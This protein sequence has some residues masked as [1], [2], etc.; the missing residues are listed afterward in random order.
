MKSS[1]FMA[2]T[3]TPL[4]KENVLISQKFRNVRVLLPIYLKV[5]NHWA[6]ILNSVPASIGIKAN[7]VLCYHWVKRS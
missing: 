3:D 7:N 2:T 6:S 1:F 4:L 5:P